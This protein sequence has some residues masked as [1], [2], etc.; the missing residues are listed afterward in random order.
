MKNGLFNRSCLGVVCTLLAT[1]G[2]HYAHAQTRY[3]TWAE[4]EEEL[5]ET[6][7]LR[8]WIPMRDGVRL[9]AEIYL[10]STASP[11]YPTVL[12][13]SP[14]PSEKTLRP[15]PINV[16]FVENGYAIV[17]QNERGRY[18]SEGDY[19]YL[20]RAGEDG[21]DT[22]D[23]IAQQE[24]SN[25]KVGTIGCSSSAENQLKLISAAHPAHAA[26]IAQA[27]GAGI[28]RIGPYSEQ[29]NT[30]RG[31]VL[32][33]LF[34]SWHHDYIYYGGADDPRP[35][36]PSDLSREDRVRL[37]KYFKLWPDYGWGEPREGF[38]YEQYYRHLPVSELNIAV[39]GPRTPWD[40]FARRTPADPA[41]GDIHLSNEGDTFGV[42]TLWA[43][44]W[45]DISVGPNVALY[46]YA[47]EHTS[48]ERARGNQH[49]IL[50]P[51]RHCAFGSETEETRVGDRDLGDARFDYTR[52]YLDWFDRWL[53]DRSNGAL[54]E[55]KVRWYQMGAN[56]WVTGDA[57]PPSGTELVDLYLSSGGNANTLYGD[58][59]LR[60]SPPSEAASD[61]YVYDP[62]RPVQTHGGGA[63]CMGDVKATGAFDQSTLE[64]R[65]DILVYTTPELEEDLTVA[66]FVEV[67]LYVS[68]DAK[69]TDFTVKLVDVYPDGTA[70]NLDDNIFRARYREGYDKK[71]LMEP[72]EVY[73]LAFAPMITANTFLKGH[74]VRIEV[75]SSNFPRYGRNLNTG[76]NNYDESEPVVAR[77][78]IHHSARHPSRIRLPVS[79]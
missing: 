24:W 56:E 71:V 72:G 52:R 2:S 31:G 55:P 76:G 4:L 68:S 19:E 13:R 8:Q 11:P 36:Y 44:S 26:A 15:S 47:R 22:V 9:D 35:I 48:T 70:Y 42:P 79:P 62:L 32:Q 14:Y 49:M 30:F 50:G 3:A 25:G 77:N 18:W 41:W 69:D 5:I 12:I 78:R 57:F 20:A 74:R 64:M 40:R 53:K 38:D 45:Y 51:T 66:G 28:G 65:G 58:G 1:A 61:G 7:I 73:K 63:C 17:Y 10:P 33:L 16:A 21:Y 60:D 46:N 29:G 27:P 54:E 67:E 23:W 6:T 39:D 34:A 75:S 37:S 43:F 59:V